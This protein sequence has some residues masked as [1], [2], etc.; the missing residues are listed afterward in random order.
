[1]P[2][3][4]TITSE[5]V[6]RYA[7]TG[8]F[9][10]AIALCNKMLR[11]SPG[12]RLDLLQAREDQR[13]EGLQERSAQRNFLEYADRMQKAGKVDEAFRALKEF[14]DLCPDQDEIRL[15]L[16]EQLVRAGRKDEAIEQLQMLH[17]RLRR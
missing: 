8:F 9:N 15:M 4:S 10:N 16:A 5:A 13:A 3:P 1:M 7:E 14:A 2:T 12:P 17:E 11:H 6:D